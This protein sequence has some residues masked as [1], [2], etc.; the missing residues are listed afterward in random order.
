MLSTSNCIMKIHSLKMYRGITVVTTTVR[1]VVNVQA[2]KVEEIKI[3]I[4]V[5]KRL[6]SI[7]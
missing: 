3:L 4:Y 5:T 7:K 1:E 6:S 2:W